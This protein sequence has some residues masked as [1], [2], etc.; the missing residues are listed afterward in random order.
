VH[1][2]VHYEV[3]QELEVAPS[4]FYEAQRVGKGQKVD[5]AHWRSTLATAFRD[6]KMGS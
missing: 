5:A 6:P 2:E 1:I 4:C 3:A